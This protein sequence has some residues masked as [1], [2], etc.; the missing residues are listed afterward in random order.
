VA[1]RFETAQ[2]GLS[3]VVV[4]GGPWLLQQLA[5][6]FHRRHSYTESFTAVA[7]SLSPLFLLRILNAAPAIDSWIGWAIG[8]F[9]SLA[10]LYRGLPRILKPDPSNALGL[11]LLASLLLISVTGLSHFLAVLVL[12]EKVLAS[13]WRI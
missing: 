4:L 11:Y 3:L 6:S 13:G 2:L 8:I 9:L 12:D 10:A 7:Y 5:Q 1:L